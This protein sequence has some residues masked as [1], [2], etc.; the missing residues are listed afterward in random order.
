VLSRAVRL[1]HSVRKLMI[2]AYVN[3][4]VRYLEIK[5]LKP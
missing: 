5:R 1:A 3:D 2:F 4:E